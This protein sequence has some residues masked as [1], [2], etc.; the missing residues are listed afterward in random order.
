MNILL[1][2]IFGAIAGWV[3]SMIM[4][5]EN[6]QS[7]LMDVVFG[8]VGAILAGWVASLL[9]QSS[10]TGFNIYSLVIAIIGASALIGAVNYIQNKS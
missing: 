2:V 10:I 7:L 9:G 3:A 5:T 1:W 4:K 6:R 8:I